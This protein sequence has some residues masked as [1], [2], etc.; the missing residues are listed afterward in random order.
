MQTSGFKL[1]FKHH[2]VANPASRQ[3]GT[4]ETPTL[5]YRLES[6]HWILESL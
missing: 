3:P 1:A 4:L 5:K 6:S 2:G